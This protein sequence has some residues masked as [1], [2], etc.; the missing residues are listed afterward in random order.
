MIA[1]AQIA[2][3]SRTD[4]IFQTS[5][6]LFQRRNR[7]D[8]VDVKQ[9]NVGQSKSSQTIVDGVKN[10]HSGESNLIG[11][12]T[13]PDSHLRCHEDLLS[14]NGQLFQG[15]AQH[16]FR[17]SFRIAVRRINEVDPMIDGSFYNLVNLL[18]RYFSDGRPETLSTKGHG[19][20]AKLGNQ[21][22]SFA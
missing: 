17:Q 15:N 9:V 13:H 18:L 7:I 11:S 2:H 21:N 22:T 20:K 14:G 6:R 12:G 1:D 10:M 5:H 8:A 4:H 19:S 3:F 16:G